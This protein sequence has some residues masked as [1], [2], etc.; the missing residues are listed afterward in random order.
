MPRREA[1]TGGKGQFSVSLSLPFYIFLLLCTFSLV[2]TNGY[3]YIYLIC[4]PPYVALCVDARQALVRNSI[5]R[6][7]T[8][9]VSSTKPQPPTGRLLSISAMDQMRRVKG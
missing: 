7:D 5:L 9:T 4:L 3:G 8:S 6:L 1:T 2:E